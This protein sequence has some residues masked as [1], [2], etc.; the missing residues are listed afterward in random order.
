M[1]SLS[2]QV[3]SATKLPIFN[4]NEFD[5]WKMRIEQYF[6][7]T[8]YSLWEVILNGDS[9]IP[10][11]DST[12]DSVSAVVNVSA[13]GTKLSA[14]TLPNVDSLSNAVIYSFFASQS[15]SSQLNNEDLKQIDVDDL[16]EM[17][18]KWQMAMLT[19]RARRFLQKTGRN[20]GANGPTSMGLDMEKVAC[21]NCYKKGHF[22]RECRSPKDS[23][24]TAV[25]EL[26]RRNVPVETS[27]SNALVSQC[28]GLESVKARLLVYKQNEY[29]LEENIKLLNI[30]VQVRDT[31][32]TTLRQKLDTTEKEIDD[33]NMMLEKFQTS[34]KILTDLLASQ[35]SKK[36]GLWYNSQ[37]FTKAMFDCDNYY[38]S[39][40]DSDSWPPSN[41]YDRF[42]LSGGYH[43]VPPPIIRTFM[44]S[45][46]DLV[47]HTPLSDKNEHLAFNVSK[48]VPS[49]AQSPE[50]VKSPRHSGQLCQVPISV[51]PSVPLRSNPYS[52]GSRKTKKA[53]FF[54]KSMDHLIK[55][56][57]FHARKLAQRSYASRDIHKQYAPVNH[58]KFPLHKVSVVALSQ[59]QNSPFRVNAAK[60]SAV[61]AAQELNRGYVAF[62]G[63]PKGGKITR[64]GKIKTGKLDFDDVYF[65]KELKFNLF[66]V[67]QMLGHVNFKTINKLVKENLVRGLPSKVFTNDNSCV[68]CKKG[69]QHRA[70][71]ETPSVLKTFIIRLENLLSLKVKI[72]RCD[73][74][75]K[76]KNSDL[77]QF[78]G[79]KGI[80]REFIVPRT[81][82]QNGFAEKKNRTLI[83]ATRTL[84]ADSLLPIPFLAKAVNTACYVQ[85]RVL[86]TKPHNKTPYELLHG[87]LPSSSP[88]W[89][90]D[91]DSLSHTM[92]YHP[93]LKE[94]QNN[95]NA[96]FQDTKKA[97]EEETQTYVLFPMLSHGSINS[98]NNIKDALADRKEHDDDHDDDTQKSVSPDIHSSS[99]G[100]QTRKQGDKTENKDKVNAASSSV[101]TAGQNSI[102]STNDFSA[103]GPSNAAMPNL[104]D[105]S[106]DADDVGAEAD[107]NNLESI[108]SVSPIPTTRIHK[109][110]LTSQIIGDL[111][112]TTQ[113]KS[114]ARAVRDQGGISQMFNEDFHTCMFACFLS[115][116]EPKRKV[117]ILVNLPYG[118]RAIG[119]KWVYK[120]KKDE[121]G[122]VIRNQARLVA[123][124]HTQEES[125]DYEVVFA[126][127]A[128][129]EAT[130][131]FLAYA[132]FMGF[133]VYQMDVKS[134]FLCGTIEEEVYVCQPLGFEDLENPN[135]VYKMVKALYG[136]HQ[137]PRAWYETLATYLLENGFQRGTID[138]TLFIKKQ[139]V[140]GTSSTEAEYVAAVS[141]CTQVLW[142]QN[143][144]LDYGVFNSPM[145]PVLRVEM[146]INSPWMLSKNWLVQKQA[147]FGKDISNPFMAD[148][149]PKMVWSSTH[150][151]T[152]MKSWLVQKQT[153]L[154]QTTTSKEFSNPFMAG[155]LPKT[156]MLAF[157]K[158]ICF[159]MSPF[160]FMFVYL[161]VTSIDSPLL[162]DN[163][164]RSDEDRLKLMEL[165]VLLLQKGVCVDI[166]ITA[167]HLSSYCCQ[168]NKSDAAEGFEQ[169]IDFLGGSY[170]DYAFTVS[171]HIYILCIKQFW[172][173]ALVKRSGDV[174]RLQALADKK[175]IVIS[176]AVIREILQ[177]NDA[178]G[179]VCLPNEEIFVGLA[180]MGSEKPSTKLTFYKAFFSSQRKF[181]IHTI[182]QSLSAKRT[183]WNEFSTTMASAVICLS[184]GQKFNFSKYIFDSLVRNVDSSSKF[185][186]YPRFIQLIIQNQV[187]DLSTHTTRFISPALTQKVFANMRRVGKGFSVDAAVAAVVEENVT[188]DVSHDAIPSPPPHDI[189]SPSQ[190]PSSPPQQQQSSPQAPPHDAE[191]PSQLQQCLNVC[192]SLS[193]RVENLETADAAQKLEIVQLKPRV[194][195][196]EKA[197]K[198]KSSKL[199]HL[200]KVGTSRRVESSDDIEDVFN[201]GRMIANMDMNE[202]IKLVKD[203]EFAKSEGR[204]AAEHAEKQ[205]EIYNLD[206]DQSLKVLSMQEHDLEVQEVVEVVTTAKLITE[207]VT[208]ATSQVS[209]A[210]T[211]IPAASA[212]I[213]AAKPTIPAAVPTVGAAYI[214]RRK[215]VIIRDP[216]E[217]L[218]LKTPAET[219]KPLKKKDQIEMDA[220]YAKKLQEEID[221][222]HDGFNKDIDWDAAIDHKAA[223]RRKLSE[224]AQEAKDLRKQ[225]KVLKM[226]MMMYLVKL[227]LLQAR[228][229]LLRFTLEQ[230]VNVTRLQ[231]EEESEMSLELLRDQ[232]NTKCVNAVS[233]ELTAAKHKLILLV[234]CWVGKGFSGVEKPLF[235]N[236][237]VVR[238]VDEEEEAHVQEPAAEEV[239]N[240][241]VLPTPT[242]PSP[243]SPVIPSSPPHQ[244]P[245]PPQP[246]D[247][248]GSSLLFQRV[249][250][251]CSALVLR[252]ED[253]E[254]DKVAQQLEIVKLKARVKKLEKINKGR[255][256]VD[257]D[258]DEGIELVIDQE[259]DVKAEGRHANKQA[260]IYNIDLDHSLKVLS[261]QEDDTKVQEAVEVVTTAKLMIEV[262]TAAT[263]QVAAASTPILTAKP[264]TLT[265]TAG[266]AVSTRKRE[267]VVIRDPEEDLPSDTPAETPKVKDKGK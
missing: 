227:L 164:P 56:C 237:L 118:K 86:V 171:P 114:M 263:T 254:N 249:L 52:K 45:K 101:S 127:V 151:V 22:A 57:D 72:I 184:K 9:P 209:A 16:E 216:E 236:M 123:Q 198:L 98:Q 108:I 178:E 233:E 204:N 41:L 42:V 47:F 215:G 169:I 257:M 136:L 138:Q 97:G 253:L 133:L 256:V 117:W 89:L 21:Y 244:P 102:N 232:R 202:G 191:F 213:L 247:A 206:L 246:Q 88:A 152:C 248:E 131:L 77:N 111:S 62:G 188:K 231:V 241:V 99:S 106:Y 79:L 159:H 150:H 124:G 217:E 60:V 193:K 36:A 35:T 12:T 205:A 196:L 141:G 13:V 61:S 115:Q 221:R 29:V 20:L 31:A 38:S 120:N 181:M 80:K 30:E 48:D 235:E 19:M 258:Q 170:I 122:I 26:Q 212:T 24:R 8:D 160:E 44:P 91:I 66:S 153:A 265:I 119:T 94:N 103:A 113:T 110:H 129:V 112:S 84:L 242:S 142:I 220:E 261:I 53:Y 78:C 82:Q 132:S 165:M 125:I 172:N 134:A 87:R 197:N 34:S 50:L 90:F 158:R 85:N 207:V 183:S 177:L 63:N 238:D 267:G 211:T 168:A 3:V 155:S 67:S 32:L 17:D 145:L 128:R 37:V 64:K 4:P 27:T 6:L 255:I 40:S 7:M 266:P 116:E 208:T 1:D 239:A 250:D 259:K 245:C 25:A 140:V 55:D 71:Y 157:L 262:V 234:Y 174:T 74:G 121:R 46:P 96:G 81:L 43:D 180:Q 143:Q 176:E 189:P 105:L 218:S 154:G 203:A 51:A 68:A 15:S 225:L 224:E 190:A 10:T 83:K 148:N 59:S 69:K 149:L 2:P 264:K 144:L 23:R 33:L 5:L 182:L 230:L 107:I 49:F 135:K 58:S 199:R 139:T 95:S 166:G 179:V 161:V 260:E 173:T 186:M 65:A 18:M 73:N 240:D 54:C 163:T 92:N 185:Y 104:E 187:G 167:A 14:S 243:S 175:K 228:Y 210:S 251:T 162:G 252:V 223:K 70:S 11:P 200:R 229:L 39:K 76:F 126:P 222:D 219:P 100:A 130:R 201:Q 192:S 93:V 214:R 194:K 75:T 195:K 156:I 147:A 137:A 146:V 28:D 226:R 109:D